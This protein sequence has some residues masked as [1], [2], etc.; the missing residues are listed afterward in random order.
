MTEFARAMQ[1]LMDLGYAVTVT[2]VDG[3]LYEGIVYNDDGSK[4]L[5][6]GSWRGVLRKLAYFVRYQEVKDAVEKG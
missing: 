1:N 5:Y 6:A 3:G 4:T 2:K